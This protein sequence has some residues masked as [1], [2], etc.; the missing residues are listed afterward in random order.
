MPLRAKRSQ[1][2][3]TSVVEAQL[4]ADSLIGADGSPTPTKRLLDNLNTAFTAV[5]TLELLANMFSHWL[6]DFVSN[7]WSAAI[8]FITLERAAWLE[9]FDTS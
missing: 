4:P 9:R 1:N 7:S 8:V 3:C 2:F 5:F 6:S